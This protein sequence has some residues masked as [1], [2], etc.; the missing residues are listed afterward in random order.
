MQDDR[1]K[2]VFFLDEKI[3]P[4]YA[5]TLKLVSSDNPLYL[6]EEKKKNQKKK[7]KTPHHQKHNKWS[8]IDLQV[9][10]SVLQ[11]S[12]NANRISRKGT[13]KWDWMVNGVHLNSALLISLKGPKRFHNGYFNTWVGKAET[14][15]L[16]I[17]GQPLCLCTT[18]ER[19]RKKTLHDV[20]KIIYNKKTRFNTDLQVN[21]GALYYSVN[22][23]KQSSSH[24]SN[25]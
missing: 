24:K 12:V 9:N 5:F 23:K 2:S 20:K 10:N 1:E 11:C 3:L 15:P 21:P 16:P 22:A 13:N 4:Q 17:R 8:Y 7:L 25:I 14:K 6:V 18:A 19:R